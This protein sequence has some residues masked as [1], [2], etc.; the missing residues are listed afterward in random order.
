MWQHGGAVPGF[1]RRY[2]VGPRVWFEVCDDV[3]AAIRR[4]KTMQ[5]WLRAWKIALIEQANATWHDLYD[6]I[7]G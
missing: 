2:G 4:E 6:Q 1:S 5:H 7:A 3:T